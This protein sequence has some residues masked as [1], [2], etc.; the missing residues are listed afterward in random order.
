MSDILKLLHVI[1]R[2]ARR[3]KFE[4]ILKCH[5]WYLC[6]KSVQ[7]M[8]L[9][10]YTSTCKGFVIFICRYFK[11]S[12][13]TTA[14]SRSNC[15]NFSCS[16][17]NTRIPVHFKVAIRREEKVWE[18]Y[19]F[20]WITHVITCWI[21]FHSVLLP[22]LKIFPPPLPPWYWLSVLCQTYY[23]MSISTL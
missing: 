21:G 13:N 17:I 16:S 18:N 14:L 6:Q 7:I 4:T 5:E 8:P 1:S 23:H 22:L 10:V 11:L 15:R 9:F 20:L 2:A 3:V 12:W 19:F